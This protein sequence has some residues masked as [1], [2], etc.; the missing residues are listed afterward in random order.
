MIVTR[1]VSTSRKVSNDLVSAKKERLLP[2][3]EMPLPFVGLSE[4]KIVLVP[5]QNVPLPNVLN[6]VGRSLQMK[7]ASN[8]I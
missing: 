4:E 7:T 3:L 2:A 1:T 5:L 6:R 8:F